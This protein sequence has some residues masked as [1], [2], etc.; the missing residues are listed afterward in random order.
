MVKRQPGRPRKPLPGPHLG[1]NPGT[2][3][4][5]PRV[6][7]SDQRGALVTVAVVPID[8][9]APQ[10]KVPVVQVAPRVLSLHDAAR[11]LGMS[12]WTIRDMEHSGLLPRIRVPLPNNGELRKLLFARE[13]LDRAVEAWKEKRS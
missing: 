10:T 13:D 2:P 12:E 9:I 5:N 8:Q 3:M 6:D 4:Q 7:G 1:H 11:Y